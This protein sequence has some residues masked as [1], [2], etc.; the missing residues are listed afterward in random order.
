MAA[1]IAVLILVA[2]STMIFTLTDPI[3]SSSEKEQLK[4]TAEKLMTQILLD[5]GSPTNWG[6][7][8][9]EV[10]SLTSFGLA[11]H[12]GTSREAYDLD[13]DKVQR[14]SL[15]TPEEFYVNTTISAN[16]LNLQNDYG[17]TFEL[18]ETLNVKITS[19]SQ[20]HERYNITVTSDY[21][22]SPINNATVLA[23]L[24]Y[25]ED[26][27]ITN[28]NALPQP[29]NYYGN[30]TIDFGITTPDNRMK[31]IIVVV[32][33]LG[34]QIAKVDLLNSFATPSY[35]LG[36][37]LLEG[38]QL[39]EALEVIAPRENGSYTIKDF[40]VYGNPSVSNYVLAYPPEESMVAILGVIEDS[41]L[42]VFFRDYEISYRT[43]QTIRS[44]SS[45]YSLE[46]TVRIGTSTYTATLYLWRRSY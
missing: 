32:N 13:P 4:V 18:N 24:Y 43:S 19:L 40:K 35:L 20:I 11:K 33:Y 7:P 30:C 36:N 8:E 46:R 15:K 6:N 1:I 21:A 27:K 23:S 31:A 17:F 2:S 25:L 37:E 3:T 14:L 26:D 41:Q 22:H 42:L 44:A 12:G 29:T 9:V 5:P 45:A 38:F 16:I 28:K 10:D 39:Q 34:L